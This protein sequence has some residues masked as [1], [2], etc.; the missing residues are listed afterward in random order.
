MCRIIYSPHYRKYN[1]GKEHPFSPI[2]IEML[3][4]LLKELEPKIPFTSPSPLSP[5]E[6]YDIHDPNY[7]SAVESASMGKEVPEADRYGLGTAD[8]P[9]VAGMAEGARFLAG[10]SVH[11]ARLLLENES[12]PVLQLGGGLH[13]A[14]RAMASGF[15]LYNDT[16]LAINEMVKAGWHVVYLDLDVH[17]GDGVQEIFYSNEQ[18]MTISLHES[19]EFLFP[20]TGWVHELGRGM[21]RALKLNIPLQPFT[22]GESYLEILRGILEPALSWFRPNAMVVQAGADAHYSDPLADLMLTSRDFQK[23]YETVLEFAAE[24]CGNRILFTLGG[25][26]RIQATCRIW[27]ILSLLIY[28]KP[29][30]EH[31]PAQWRKKWAPL[32]GEAIPEFLHDPESCYKAIPRKEEI[33]K[34]NRQLLRKL[35]DA[36]CSDW[37]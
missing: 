5:E 30:P 3:V 29:L 12:G 9:I 2:R 14:H 33:T 26:Y 8:T 15:C 13:H 21:G 1:L 6:L 27:A 18:V 23:I 11:G 32:A 22:E 19:G 25:G 7:V 37:L 20:G 16:A 10:G 31:L 34:L 17:H 4:D 28:G 35:L 24:K 36:T